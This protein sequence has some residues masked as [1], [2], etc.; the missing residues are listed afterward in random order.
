MYRY[1]LLCVLSWVCGLPSAFGQ[2][3]ATV[4]DPDPE[5]ERKSFILPEGFEVNLYAADPLLAKP[6]QM[7]FDP[8]GRLW[9]ASSATYPQIKPGEKSN[10]KVLILEDTNHDGKA[11]KTTIYADGLLIPTGVAPG[12]GGVY[13]A[14]S[15]DLVHF[16]NPDPQTGKARTKRIVLS[17]FG[18]E[19]THH[20]LHTFRWGPDSRLFMTQSI[21]IHSHIETPHGVRRLNAGGI[22][23]FRPSTHELDVFARGFINSWGTAWDQWGATFATDG[24]HFFGITPI[25]PGAYYPTA[26]GSSRVLE[27]LNPGSPKHCGLEVVSGRHLPDSWQG[28]LITN[29]FRGHRVCRF[30][31]TE[32]GSTFSSRELPELIKTTHPAFRPIDVKMGPDGAIYIADWYNPII[33]HGEVD[34]RDPRRDKTH[35]RIWRITAKNR[36]LV[37]KPVLVGASVADLLEQLQSPEQW[38]RDQARRVLTERGAA[39]VQPALREWVAQLDTQSARYEH[40]RLEALWLYQSLNIVNRPLLE[41]ILASPDFRVRAAACRVAG[42]WSKPLLESLAP[43]SAA[44]LPNALVLLATAAVDPAPR[45][46]LEAVRALAELHSVEAAAAAATALDCPVDKWLD[47][48]IWLTLRDLAP[49]WLPKLTAGELDF[50]GDPK[51]IVFA[52]KAAGTTD[53]AK[54][55]VKLWKS[56]KIGRDRA[57]DVLPLIASTGGPDELTVVWL[58]AGHLPATQAELATAILTALDSSAR[59]RNVRPAAGVPEL[60][61]FLR[62]ADERVQTAAARLAGAWKTNGVQSDLARIATDSARSVELRRAACDGLAGIGDATAQA[63]LTQ[64]ATGSLPPADRALA[65]AALASVERTRAATLATDLLTAT[66]PSDPSELFA[67]FTSRKGGAEALTQALGER[68]LAADTAKIGVRVA[69]AAAQPSAP[70]IAALTRSGKLGQPKKYTPDEVKQLL[71]AIAE[72]GDP[73]RGER[74]FRK[75]ELN[76]LKCHA[77]AGAGGIIGPEMTSIGASAQVDYLVDSL[78]DPNKAVKE[79]YHSLIVNTLDG[80]SVTGIKVRESK[81]ELVLRDAEGREIAIPTANIDETKPGRSLMPDNLHDPLTQGELVDLV[82]FLSALGKVGGGFQAT[83]GRVVRRWEAIQPTKELAY[84]L[85][86]QR[87]GAIAGTVNTLTWSPMYSLVS[88]HL[89][90]EELPTF[91]ASHDGPRTAAVRFRF[92]QTVAGAVKL[93]LNAPK[94]LTVWV[95]GRP[96]VPAPETELKLGAGTHTVTLAIATTVRREPL[97]VEVLDVPGSP[98]QPQL[99]AGK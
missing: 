27:G 31:V 73:A 80:K 94:G 68:S 10:D 22:W 63:E 49:Q 92:T 66:P 81:T 85:G 16:S 77:I 44:P 78:L 76:C 99:E 36:P 84:L 40:H 75:A 62:H 2:R 34:F 48:A 93:V 33:Q 88:G 3:D 38:T 60:A 9:I 61:S 70:L 79:G 25:V 82:R 41:A 37:P 47:Y 46:R 35:G 50:G 74:V 42:A 91:R 71:T 95:D 43:P 57:A 90:I 54:P 7:N 45:V 28:N 26:Q 32:D 1:F 19:D 87:V 11:D 23:Q 5:I 14:D 8:Q 24:A 55:L 97:R 64:I 12:D 83:P 65:I 29:D 58:E 69:R 67:A 30:V 51:K 39:A 6:I 56:G 86:R 15:T 59:Q 98:A 20:I 52:L 17:G 72:K 53:V 96:V 21:Y 4:P 13:V 89:P 18:T